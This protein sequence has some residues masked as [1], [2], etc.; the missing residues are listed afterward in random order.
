MFRVQITGSS[1]SVGSEF[2]DVDIDD[3]ED[4]VQQH[5]TG[6]MLCVTL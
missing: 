4:D 5:W 3:D 1:C 6:G 2:G